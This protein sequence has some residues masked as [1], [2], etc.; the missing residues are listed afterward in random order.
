[1]TAEQLN[2][3]EEVHDL[4]D[5][6]AAHYSHIR[7]SDRRLHPS[8]AQMLHASSV[9][10]VME[11]SSS[12]LRHIEALKKRQ[13]TDEEIREM[14]SPYYYLQVSS[15][16]FSRQEYE[17]SLSADLELESPCSLN[18]GIDEDEDEDQDDDTQDTFEF[19]EG[20]EETLGHDRS[21]DFYR[22]AIE[23]DTFRSRSSDEYP[24]HMELGEGGGGEPEMITPKDATAF[25]PSRAP[26]IAAMMSAGE[27]SRFYGD[28]LGREDGA[29]FDDPSFFQGNLGAD[30]NRTNSSISSAESHHRRGTE[31]D[32][33]VPYG[34]PSGAAD[35]AAAEDHFRNLDHGKQIEQASTASLGPASPSEDG[36]RAVVSPD[37]TSRVAYI[38]FGEQMVESRVV[39]H[40]PEARTRQPAGAV[41]GKWPAAA[42]GLFSAVS[43]SSHLL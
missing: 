35:P 30:M 25:M 42:A 3:E 2:V 16:K 34:P 43:K 40:G 7:P 1:L 38:S 6:V 37:D 29:S 5:K 20:E 4:A 33:R 26:G 21:S 24:A 39:H 19:T 18:S 8:R 14:Q 12:T 23:Q 9:R 13:L 15:A 28:D 11:R 36:F 17:N 41:A 32:S 10:A 31:E 22:K 27:P